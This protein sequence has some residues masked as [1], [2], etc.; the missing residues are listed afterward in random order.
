MAPCVAARC[1]ALLHPA[2]AL[3]SGLR[4]GSTIH[5]GLE[6]YF[7]L[8]ESHSVEPGHAPRG[9]SGAEGSRFPDA[10]VTGAGLRGTDAGM[11]DAAVAGAGMSGAGVASAVGAAITVPP[12]RASPRR[13][14]GPCDPPAPCYSAPHESR[15]TKLARISGESRDALRQQRAAAAAAQLKREARPSARGSDGDEVGSGGGG[16]GGGGGSGCGS[17]T[18]GGS[19]KGLDLGTAIV[20]CEG[21]EAGLFEY[22][23]LAIDRKL[24]A[25][26][27]A[28]GWRVLEKFKNGRKYGNWSYMGPGQRRFN[29]RSEALA[30]HEAVEDGNMP[31]EPLVPSPAKRG[32]PPDSGVKREGGGGDVGGGGGAKRQ[33]WPTV[34]LVMSRGGFTKSEEEASA[35]AAVWGAARAAA[36]AAATRDVPTCCLLNADC[37]RP[38]RHTGRCKVRPG[39]SA[40]VAGAAAAGAVA[41]GAVVAATEAAAVTVQEA[42]D[43]EDDEQSQASRDAPAAPPVRFLHTFVSRPEAVPTPAAPAATSASLSPSAAE[44]EELRCTDREAPVAAPSVELEDEVM[45]VAVCQTA[46][47]DGAYP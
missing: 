40:A 6:R 30:F 24:W 35:A 38:Y 11:S 27:A 20:P 37:V 13:P 43:E 9:I 22:V 19:L 47:T 7:L 34:R 17:R 2:C 28:A 25:G 12:A 15:D 46:T 31:L 36:R 42:E 8:C 18:Y 21:D 3:R 32:R 16:G 1:T 39:E 45:L 26:A 44:A 10:A 5:F 23:P 29:T 41:A 14:S 33:K 4:L